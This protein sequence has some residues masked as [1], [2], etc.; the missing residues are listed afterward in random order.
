M[1]T[2]METE[3]YPEGKKDLQPTNHRGRGADLP[4]TLLLRGERVFLS[5]LGRKHSKKRGRPITERR[6][7][8]ERGKE[9]RLRV[10]MR[11]SIKEGMPAGKENRSKYS[12]KKRYSK[13]KSL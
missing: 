11:W 10:N 3:K 6:R 9:S 7:C 1:A 12:T 2:S 4:L 5:P 13:E 8:C